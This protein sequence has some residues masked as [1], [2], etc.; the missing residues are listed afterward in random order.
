ML[1][2]AIIFFPI[3]IFTPFVHGANERCNPKY[4]SE[5]IKC[6]EQQQKNRKVLN[7]DLLSH[8]IQTRFNNVAIEIEILVYISVVR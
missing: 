2:K 6:I 1:L 4:L 3:L 7:K 8:S 5:K